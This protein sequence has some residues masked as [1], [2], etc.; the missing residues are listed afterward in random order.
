[1]WRG[2]IE[3]IKIKVNIK[4]VVSLQAVVVSLPVI[5]IINSK[6][7]AIERLFHFEYKYEIKYTYRILNAN[8]QLYRLVKRFYDKICLEYYKKRLCMYHT[9][10]YVLYSHS[11]NRNTNYH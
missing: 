9:L 1:M 8:S 3:K 6:L 5:D 7:T 2:E 10:L 11:P 4:S